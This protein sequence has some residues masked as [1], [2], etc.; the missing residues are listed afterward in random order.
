M[1]ARSFSRLLMVA[2][3]TGVTMYF[4]TS[5]T[6]RAYKNYYKTQTHVNEKK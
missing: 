3:L 4:L 1:T 5:C 6:S 2:I